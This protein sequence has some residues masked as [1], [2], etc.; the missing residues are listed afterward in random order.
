MT[1]DGKKVQILWKMVKIR[2]TNKQ[3]KK[4][5]T[6]GQMSDRYLDYAVLYSLLTLGTNYY[7]RIRFRIFIQ[8]FGLKHTVYSYVEFF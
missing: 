2:T 4:Q 7:T 1:L 3:T 5:V 8:V 6:F